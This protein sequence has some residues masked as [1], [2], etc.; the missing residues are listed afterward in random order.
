MVDFQYLDEGVRIRGAWFPVPKVHWVFKEQDF[1]S[2]TD[3]EVF[4]TLWKLP[5]TACRALV[6]RFRI[7]A[8]ITVALSPFAPRKRRAFAERKPTLISVAD[9]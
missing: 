2:P 1:N 6:G 9:P 5:D 3:S 8:S 7:G 4:Q